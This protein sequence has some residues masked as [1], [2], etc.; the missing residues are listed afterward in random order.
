MIHDEVDTKALSFN[1]LSEKW[2]L[3]TGLD[4]LWRCF[5][6]FQSHF[7]TWKTPPHYVILWPRYQTR[8]PFFSTQT[9]T[10]PNF[11]GFPWC[12]CFFSF[13][14]S[15]SLLPFKSW[16][17]PHSCYFTL[18]SPSTLSPCGEPHKFEVSTVCCGCLELKEFLISLTAVH[19][20]THGCSH[21]CFQ[22]NWPLSIL[23]L[24]LFANITIIHWSPLYLALI[25]PFPSPSPCN[26]L[27]LESRFHCPHAE[28]LKRNKLYFKTTLNIHT[29]I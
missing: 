21:Q 28:N 23:N 16:H 8:I 13:I 18:Y 9:S 25:P 7:P 10:P 15:F 6:L 19:C 24:L 29:H 4:D 14:G 17:F 1:F 2:E 22:M 20:L 26:Q 5:W 11:S 3:L 12:L 27:S